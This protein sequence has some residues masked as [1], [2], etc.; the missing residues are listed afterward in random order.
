MGVVV[1]G[2]VQEWFMVLF[3]VLLVVIIRRFC[4]FLMMLVV[5]I[6]VIVVIG[7]VVI[8]GVKKVVMAVICLLGGVVCLRLMNI[9]MKRNKKS[10]THT[11]MRI[12]FNTPF[13]SNLFG[14]LWFLGCCMLGEFECG[15]R[16]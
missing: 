6:V 7:G 10:H 12:R 14:N 11:P 15:R 16:K 2:W 4:L 3:L 9:P 1:K 8:V 5:I 13:L